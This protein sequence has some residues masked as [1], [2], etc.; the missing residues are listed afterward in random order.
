MRPGAERIDLE[1]VR[2][3]TRMYHLSPGPGRPNPTPP[4]YS[5]PPL[6]ARRTSIPL[7]LACVASLAPTRPPLASEVRL[8]WDSAVDPR[9]AIYQLDYG[10]STKAYHRHLRT[11]E[12][13][14][15][16]QDLDPGRQYYFAVRACTADQSLCSAYSAEL[17]VA[18][19]YMAQTPPQVCAA[20]SFPLE[21]LP[22]RGGWRAI[23][24]G[25]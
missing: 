1:S 15:A 25:D 22:S 7:V 21:G 3:R 4:R 9:V 8:A 18:I 23:L 17:C 19:P 24:D 11:I 5:R 14:L 20:N 10:V 2:E 13:S 16:I 6:R 12:P